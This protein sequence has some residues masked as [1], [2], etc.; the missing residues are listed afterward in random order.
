MSMNHEPHLKADEFFT[1]GSA[2]DDA[3]ESVEQTTPA[4]LIEYTPGRLIALPV[5]TTYGLIEYPSYMEVPG[6]APYGYGLITWQNR[7]LPLL[8]LNALL[9]ADYSIVQNAA[10]R[11]AL[12]VAYQCV[13]NMPLEYGAFGLMALPLNIHINNKAQCELPRDS[14]LWEQLA[15]SCFK[16]EGQAIP[17]I[18]TARVF[19]VSHCE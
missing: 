8:D 6:A 16:Y 13:S 15:L 9:H 17:I 1:V 19:A 12:I 5:H 18:D 4:R 2:S 7:R 14:H 10:P 3:T 11:Y